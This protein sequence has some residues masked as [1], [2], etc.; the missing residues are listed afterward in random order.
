MELFKKK[1]FRLKLIEYFSAAVTINCSLFQSIE[2]IRFEY[3]N[4][5]KTQNSTDE[6]DVTSSRTLLKGLQVL[7]VF[8]S[9]LSQ[10]CLHT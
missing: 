5:Y 10:M 2:Y 1:H 3:Q 9:P 4:H 8:H 7:I 6:T